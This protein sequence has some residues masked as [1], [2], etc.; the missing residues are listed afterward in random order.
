MIITSSKIALVKSIQNITQSKSPRIFFDFDGI[1]S[2]IKLPDVD[3]WPSSSYSFSLWLN[4]ENFDEPTGSQFY[5]PRL[6]R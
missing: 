4:I 2:G 3:K 5:E 6:F 1:V